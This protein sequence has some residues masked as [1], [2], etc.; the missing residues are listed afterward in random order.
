MFD[1]KHETRDKHQLVVPLVSYT[2][3]VLRVFND[4]LQ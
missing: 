4:L 1:E 2:D 3:L